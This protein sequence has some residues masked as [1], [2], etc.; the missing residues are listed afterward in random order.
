VGPNA[1]P[2]TVSQRTSLVMSQ[3]KIRAK[4]NDQIADGTFYSLKLQYCALTLSR[5]CQS[6]ARHSFSQARLAR[7]GTSIP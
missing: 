4:A 7:T 5:V 6:R 3:I 2:I 1:S